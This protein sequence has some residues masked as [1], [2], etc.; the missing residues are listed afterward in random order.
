[1]KTSFINELKKKRS[2][3]LNPDQACTQAQS[4][5]LLSSG[6]YTEE[7]RFVF[8]LLQNAV[9]A[10]NDLGSLKV[11]ILLYDNYLVFMHNGD[12]F[13]MRDIEGL[14]DVG[15]GNKMSDIKKI[16]YKGIGFKSVFMHSKNVTIE[17]GDF[18][19]KFEKS[20]W[21][22]YWDEDWGTKAMDKQVLMPWQIIPLEAQPP[23]KLDHEGYN[24]I[25]YI[26]TNNAKSL[27]EKIR[28]IL[29]TCNFLLFLRHANISVEYIYKGN[30]QKRIQK[31]TTKN[32]VELIN[33]GR[34][35]SKWLV[36]INPNVVIP[37]D[38]REVIKTDGITPIKLQEASH[39][40]L[41]FAVLLNDKDQ[42]EALKDSCIYTYLPTS[43]SFGL[44]FLVNANFI[45]DAGRQHLVNDSEWNKMIF[46]A[47]PREFLT[48][49]STISKSIKS[50]YKVL[51]SKT[52]KMDVLSRIF[53]SSLDEAVDNIAFIPTLGGNL[54]K[55]KEAIMD[56]VGISSVIGT[57]ILLQHINK[58][59]SA[60][61]GKDSFIYRGGISILKRYGVFDFN[62]E[63]LKG[64][65]E[66]KT[67]F[68]GITIEKDFEL[69]NFLYDYTKKHELDQ[70]LL[71]KTLEEVKFL[72]AEDNKLESPVNLFFPSKYREE[73][74]VAKDAKFLHE[75]IY[76]KIMSN[77]HL[78]EW[79]LNVGLCTL[80]EIGLIKNVFCKEGYITEKNAIEVGQFIF[81]V[82]K[83]RNLLEEIGEYKLSY[84]RFLT[85]KNSLKRI[86][87]LFLGHEYKPEFD[88]E[89]V[90]DTDVFV[91][92]LYANSNNLEEWGKFFRKLGVCESI[93][94]FSCLMRWENLTDYTQLF[95]KETKETVE[96]Y[97]NPYRGWENPFY[98]R[99]FRLNYLSLLEIDSTPYALAKI[100]WNYLFKNNIPV[101]SSDF[102]EGV[103]GCCLFSSFEITK[104]TK[105][106]YPHWIFRN[107]Q[108]YPTS[109]G[110]M[111]L[112]SDIYLNTP[113]IKELFGS[114][115]PYIDVDCEVHDS[116]LEYVPFN[117]NI[118]LDVYLQLL[119]KISEDTEKADENKSR[120][121]KIYQRIVEDFDINSVNTQLKIK[122][123]SKSGK[124]LTAEG[125]FEK[126][127]QLRFITLDGFG[128]KNR[129]YI[130]RGENKDKVL[131]LLELMGVSIITESS[132]KMKTEGEV[133][134]NDLKEKLLSI[135][136]VLALLKSGETCKKEDF[137]TN[138]SSIY[139]L[140]KETYFYHCEAIYL[141]YGRDDDLIKKATFSVNNKF[142]YS[143]ELRLSTVDPLLTPLCNLLDIKGKERELMVVLFENLDSIRRYLKEKEY[144]IAFIEGIDEDESH[145]FSPYQTPYIR[146]QEQKMSSEHNG[147][148]GEIIVYE[149]LKEM[150]YNPTCYSIS[151]KKDYEEIVEVGGN[152]YY[153]KRNYGN[154]DISFR[155]KNGC[156]IFVEVKSTVFAK[157]FQNQ[158]PISYNELTKLEEC[159]NSGN[160]AY[161]IARVF[162][163]GNDIQDIYFFK[164][165]IANSS[166][167]ISISVFE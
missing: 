133:E 154:F 43:I 139:A 59:L 50:Y 12:K 136:K 167:P 94:P 15:N 30:L 48:W 81:Q 116:W 128:S 166:K 11:K 83:K 162:E 130:G 125:G 35:E 56:S 115:L 16:G 157:Q 124:I 126:P 97:K 137:Q 164:G 42:V 62:E 101:F 20:C 36:Y 67:A 4:L 163:V 141:T 132:V 144:N 146:T 90:Y 60:N 71:V 27:D 51:P 37:T 58:T 34:V 72:Y 32:I 63:K 25:N 156:E 75:E 153:C 2:K 107:H 49:M 134:K 86:T 100:I 82:S 5:N 148:R 73:E 69:I 92:E 78:K 74:G 31:S 24:V 108:T 80:D 89:P 77:S 66:D 70:P 120:V 65:F 95:L 76:N 140:L 93:S 96:T 106:S 161:Y 28:K 143:G 110:E 118:S 149:K 61:Y 38:T 91:S 87:E 17:S 155:T 9:D 26:Q 44:P 18:C 109:T 29:E 152:I 123:W 1:M 117:S 99:G 33:D 64:L 88:L 23:I 142:Y 104:W 145:Q 39:F 7:E 13:T 21:E 3:Y 19:F 57:D 46:N 138:L 147:F 103:Y 10:Y 8:E 119:S 68:K 158:I 105:I 84:L 102:V 98:I 6:I 47:I 159:C 160:K 22:N 131:Q 111:L 135:Y 121:A 151:S 114:Y 53:D 55:A 150:G 40:D 45:T 122:E 52:S 41:S 54:L 85:K 79:L 113:K 127:N 112:A 129:A 165:Y 14:C